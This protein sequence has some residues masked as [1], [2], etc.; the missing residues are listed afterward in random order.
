MFF[1]AGGKLN[2]VRKVSRWR[3]EGGERSLAVRLRRK[4]GQ[5]A[6][7]RLED[8]PEA[9]LELVTE[10]LSHLAEGVLAHVGGDEGALEELGVRL[11]LLSSRHLAPEAVEELQ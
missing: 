2:G 10:L 11:L 4:D 1:G 6:V 5:Q 7:E 8:G 9:L 3:E